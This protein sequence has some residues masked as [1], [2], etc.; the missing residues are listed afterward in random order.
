LPTDGDAAKPIAITTTYIPPLFLNDN[1][2][3]S[4]IPVPEIK[5]NKRM[6]TQFQTIILPLPGQSDNQNQ[7]VIPKPVDEQPIAVRIT[8]RER[9][10]PE[11]Y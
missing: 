1:T 3:I 7:S 8:N 6:H 4:N 5:G 11:K 9:R 10:P 2:R